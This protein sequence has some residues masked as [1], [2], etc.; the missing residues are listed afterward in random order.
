MIEHMAVQTGALRAP[1]GPCRA[2]RPLLLEHRGEWRR[3]R[4]KDAL[5]L[6]PAIADLFVADTHRRFYQIVYRRALDDTDITARN[7]ETGEINAGSANY[8]ISVGG[9][10][11]RTRSIRISC[12][13]CPRGRISNS[14]WRC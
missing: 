5:R 9:M 8:P 7:S 11:A 12:S 4:I 2:L 14:A 10:P 13:F 1:R 3:N 6:P